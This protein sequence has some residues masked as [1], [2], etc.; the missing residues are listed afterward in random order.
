MV[1]DILPSQE[2]IENTDISAED[3]INADKLKKKPRKRRIFL[4]VFLA[5]ALFCLG[6]I[7]NYVYKIYIINGKILR[8]SVEVKSLE[9]KEEVLKMSLNIRDQDFLSA[10][11]SLEK[12]L[13]MTREINA[14]LEDYFKYFP[15]WFFSLSIKQVQDINDARMIFKET[16][17]ILK[18]ADF[19]VKETEAALKEFGGLAAKNENEAAILGKNIFNSRDSIEKH[20]DFIEKSLAKINRKS[21]FVSAYFKDFKN[22]YILMQNYLK[23]FK[24]ILSSMD[25]LLG[26]DFK[27]RYLVLFQNSSEIRATG[28]FLGSYGIVSL[29]K[30]ALLDF[31]VDD[32]YNPDGQLKIKSVKKIV[33]PRPL[34]GITTT[35]GARDANWFFDFKTSAQKI[36]NFLEESGAVSNI[37]GVIAINTNLIP[38]ILE[39]TGPVYLEEYQEEIS[40]ENFL[41]KIQYAVEEGP[42]YKLLNQ[43]KR[44]LTFFGPELLKKISDSSAN[45]SEKLLKEIYSLSNQKEIMFFFRD[46]RIQK[47]SEKFALDGNVLATDLGEDYLAVVNSNIAGAKTDAVMSQNLKLSAEVLPSGEIINTLKIARKH[48]GKNAKYSWWKKTNKN[49]IRVYVPKGSEFLEIQGAKKRDIRAFADYGSPNY[50]MDPDLSLVENS[51]IKEFE[52]GTDIFEESGKTV[53]GNWIFTEPGQESVLTIKYKLPFSV[54]LPELSG[55]GLPGNQTISSPAA[56]ASLDIRRLISAENFSFNYRL[57]YQKQSGVNNGLRVYFQTPVGYKLDMPEMDGN[58]PAVIFVKDQVSK[59]ETARARMVM[60]RS[61]DYHRYQEELDKFNKIEIKSGKSVKVNLSKMKIYALEGGV[62]KSEYTILHKGDPDKWYQTP[63]GFFAAGI[64]SKNHFSSV[65][66]VFMPYSI[67]MY[68]DFFIHGIPYYKNGEAVSSTFSGGCI[69]ISNNDAKSLYEFVERNTPIIVS[70]DLIDI[71]LKTGF[72]FPVDLN[73]TWIRKS[74]NSP[75]NI[76]GYY[77]KIAGTSDFSEKYYQHAGIDLASYQNIEVFAAASGKIVF[78]QENDGNDF[79]FGNVLILEHSRFSPAKKRSEKFYTLY[80]HLDKISENLKINDNASAGQLIGIMGNSGFGC[81]NYWRKGADGCDSKNE[82]DIHLHFETKSAPV[83]E[84]PFG[85]KACLN[86]KGEA[87]CCYGYTPSYPSKYGY[88]SPLEFIFS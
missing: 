62:L 19:I 60:D 76:R 74:Y 69:R 26:R 28:G 82:S 37:D 66:Q 36:L 64:K 31:I 8:Q 65:G 78:I 38:K 84:N 49:Y 22:Q 88:Y 79:G 61:V 67:E 72:V 32:I 29:E 11:N 24:M 85:G 58:S 75:F 63:T 4:I 27:R 2:K 57:V 35:W 14:E 77:D 86:K 68:E 13:V 5:L 10:K 53:F 39:I 15:L 33:P 46:E 59:I 12:S 52:S 55:G 42:D 80:A 44:I 70:E 48:N 17:N 9:L 81:Q 51:Y 7:F 43:P 56:S 54:K 71:K 30:G 34:W 87:V 3:K 16:E 21:D 20:V 41:E 45:Q 47:L 23:E 18:S 25:V 73:K 50:A 6:L 83:L 1:Y 40:A